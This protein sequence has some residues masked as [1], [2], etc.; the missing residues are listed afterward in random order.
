MTFRVRTEQRPTDGSRDSTVYVLEAG[1]GEARAEIWP[2]LGCNCYCWQVVRDGRL[3]DLLYADPQLFP[4][5]RPTRSGVPI[6]FPFPNR[7]RDGR[8]AWDGRAYQLPRN[9]ST[10]RNA[11]HGFA[12]QR[13]WRVIG[14]GANE[15][16]AWLTAE[17]HGARDAPET[18]PL[19]PADYLLRITFRL[20]MHHL[21]IEAHVEN[22]D[23]VSLP[24]G[25]GYHPYFRI[26]FLHGADVA[27]C[28]VEVSAR[29]E[30][31]LVESLPTGARR[32]AAGPVDLTTPKCFRDL[33][34]DHLLTGLPE[35][36][37]APGNGLTSIGSI[38]QQP[39]GLRLRVRSSTAFR[40]AVVF[41]PP[42]R[43][44]ICL[45]PYTCITDAINLQQK[46]LET[47]LLILGPGET[48]DSVIELSV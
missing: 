39:E 15:Q 11:I 23:Q 19:W 38:R 36:G 3:L 35:P 9:D 46:G 26:P 18:R 40:E 43:Q 1:S 4:N 17:F 28:W 16:E 5:G 6:L 42:H 31:E 21:Q 7:I 41:T 47:G 10:G 44:A 20:A 48:W 34:L 27:E 32:P 8:F 24:F 33:A 45:E 25:L 29:T 22:P 14:Q 37:P 30:W 12:C 2:G 13:S